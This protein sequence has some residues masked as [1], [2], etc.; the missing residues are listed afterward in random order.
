[1]DL[2]H[3]KAVKAAVSAF[4]AVLTALWGWFGWLVLI[5]MVCMALDWATGSAAA[6]RRG[7][8]ASSVGRDG[9]WH[10]VGALAAVMTA[11]ILDLTVGT[12]LTHVPGVALPFDYTVFFAPLVVVWYI[13]TECGSIVENAA[14]LGAT[15]PGWLAKALAALR[16]QVDEHMGENR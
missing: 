10:K 3:I 8:W 6:V 2:E 9:I 4:L 12:I 15:V 5:L 11:G 16:D 14:A 7:E 13:L 1:M